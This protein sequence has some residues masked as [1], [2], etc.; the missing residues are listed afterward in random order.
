MSKNAPKTPKI[1]SASYRKKIVDYFNVADIEKS[2][3]VGGTDKAGGVSSKTTTFLN[4]I[5][6]LENAIYD[7]KYSLGSLDE[8]RN[9]VES[10]KY[11]L[12]HNGV[13]LLLRYSPEELVD[14]SPHDLGAS[15]TASSEQQQ[16]QTKSSYDPL[17]LTVAS[18]KI[19][20]R[21]SESESTSTSKLDPTENASVVDH[22]R[23][24]ILPKVLGKVKLVSM[25]RCKHC[26]PS[27]YVE[28]YSKQTRSADEGETT[29]ANCT[30]CKRKWRA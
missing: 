15:F 21:Q 28:S 25:L 10:L 9:K 24:K 3:N 23:K 18:L 11:N 16:F 4:Y 19:E 1:L 14:V 8:Y 30:K 26:G 5:K 27:A 20:E 29:F 7:K 12:R 2:W 13:N 22:Y 6:K 17:C